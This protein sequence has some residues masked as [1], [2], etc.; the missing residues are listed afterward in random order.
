MD[1]FFRLMRLLRSHRL[2]FSLIGYLLIFALLVPP[3]KG[4]IRY[5]QTPTIPFDWDKL[6]TAI[7]SFSDTVSGDMIQQVKTWEGIPLFYAQ[8]IRT[9][10]CFD[11]KCRPLDLTVYWNITG[12]YLGFKIPDGEFLS[13]Y[14]HEP[15]AAEDYDR[16][17]TLLADPQLPFRNI[18]FEELIQQATINTDS[19]DAV[20]GATSKDLLA[21]VVEGAAYTTY[22]LW[23]IIYGPAQGA[24]R[25]LTEQAMT[26]ELLTLILNSPS[27]QDRV[28]GLGQIDKSAKLETPLE[29]ALLNIIG[30]SAYFPAYSAIN[31]IEP[32]HLYSDALQVGLFSKYQDVNHSLKK[33]IISKLKEAPAISMEL[34]SQSRKILGNLNGEQL[35]QI[36]ELY[37][38]FAIYDR[39]TARSVASLLTNNNRFISGKAYKFLVD[40][41]QKD[42]T[43]IQALHKY[44]SADN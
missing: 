29:G 7:V 19:I 37:D 39:L 23:N 32:S 6:Q 26:P 30:G 3:Q 24:V 36:L 33:L 44:Q 25:R 40:L 21:Y 27:S 16:L 12:R 4:E 34:I 14:D 31:A 9:G 41:P 20:S 11:N 13:R 2:Y 5:L 38:Q 1:H 10:V 8:D 28:W 22:T 43:I 15:F 35:G 18:T 42:E 17:H